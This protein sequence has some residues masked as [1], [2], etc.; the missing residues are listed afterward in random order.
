MGK[1]IQRSFFGGLNAYV[2][3][4][5]L[6]DTE[7]PFLQNGRTR[8]DTISPITLPKEILSGKGK[9]QGLYGVENFL[10][11]FKDGL[12][13][14]KDCN[15]SLDFFPIADFQMS[16]EVEQ[17]YVAFVPGSTINYTR[18]LNGED[19]SVKF[20]ATVAGSPA[21]MIVQDGI[22]QP[23][24]IYADG[25]AKRLQTYSQWSTTSREYVP[26]GR[27]MLYVNNKLFLVSADGRRLY[28]S[29]SGRPT[30]FVVNIDEN[31][32]KLP[33]ESEGGAESTSHAVSYEIISTLYPMAVGDGGFFVASK[34]NSFTVS[35]N[36]K[37]WLFGEPTFLN[38][39]LF[40]TGVVNNNSIVDILGDT[41]FI[42]GLGIRSYNAVFQLNY[43]GKNSIFSIKIS[44]LFKD[45]FQTTC[46][47]YGFD[48]YAFFAVDTTLGHGIMVFDTLSKTFVSFDQ[49]SNLKG[50]IKQFADIQTT[51][52]RELYCITTENKVYRLFDPSSDIAPIKVK[53]GGW[54]NSGDPKIQH[55]PA[56][57]GLTFVDVLEDGELSVNLI[58]DEI[59]VAE[60]ILYPLTASD[61]AFVARMDISQRGVEAFK[62]EVEISWASRAS[63]AI[64]SLE[65]EDSTSTT[66]FSEQAALYAK[67][68]SISSPK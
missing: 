33:L 57:L 5:K 6:N 66:G 68:K 14:I 63:L 22:S 39:F 58:S 50:K 9:V 55:T 61:K 43:E 56:R 49:Y 4:S 52:G 42:D 65:T 25:T 35:L 31:G 45:I 34:K 10:I 16:P 62:H 38:Q 44:P 67:N 2:D 47:A 7:Y 46:A 1:F 53:L 15:T 19:R 20:G 32:D 11:L 59:T 48:N 18:K 29:V 27:Q 24:L 21:G 23:W 51:S 36:W 41:A 17:F 64:V 40:P 12:C 28:Q 54:W 60:N 30:D 3:S 26:I 8:E 13:Y 37:F